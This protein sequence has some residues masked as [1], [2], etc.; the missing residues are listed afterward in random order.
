MDNI[1]ILTPD[2]EEL[3]LPSNGVGHGIKKLWLRPMTMK[4]EK[5]LT[6]KTLAKTGKVHDEIFKSCIGWGEDQKGDRI[7]PENIH[8]NALYAEDEYAM[9]I[10]LRTISYGYDY[11][12]E[13]KCPTCEVSREIQVNLEADLDVKYADEKLAPEIIVNLPKAKRKVTLT[14]PTKADSDNVEGIVD[15]IP[16]LVKSV[17]GLDDQ[18][19]PIFLQNLIG[20]DVSVIRKAIQNIPFGLSKE[21]LFI[22]NNTECD[23]SGEAQK[24]ALPITAEFFRI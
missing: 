23:K 22:C 1:Q 24:T 14:Y 19:V 16:K 15:M 7:E 9:F 20:L 12:T 21:I 5:L 10:F 8:L 17:E 3:L 6:N 18:A 13:V 11:D 2:H 4:E